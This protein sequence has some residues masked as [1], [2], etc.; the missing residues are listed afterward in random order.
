MNFKINNKVS[1]GIYYIVG[2]I[3]LILN[4][5]MILK[6]EILVIY[7][8]QSMQF[9]AYPDNLFGTL[10]FL[11]NIPISLL[12]IVPM[13][14]DFN[15]SVWELGFLGHE[16]KYN[17][18]LTEKIMLSTIISLVL[19]SITVVNGYTL[20]INTIV[21]TDIE[22]ISLFKII[23]CSFVPLVFLISTSIFIISIMRGNGF[24]IFISTG[25]YL[26]VENPA[27]ITRLFIYLKNDI[28]YVDILIYHGINLLISV[29]LLFIAFTKLKRIKM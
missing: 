21:P 11:F 27:S 9:L 25:Y 7:K 14:I 10:A 2:A 15:Y 19:Y 4:I 29:I 5:L 16:N 17:K 24:S 1:Y 18:L 28:P 3:I 8:D 13:L 12:F 22:T 26:I 23:I 6:P 20:Y